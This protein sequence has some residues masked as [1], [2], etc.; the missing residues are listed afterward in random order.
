MSVPLCGTP[1]PRL[2]LLHLFGPTFPLPLP[3]PPARGD[4][5][6]VLFW[7]GDEMIIMAGEESWSFISKHSSKHLRVCGESS[8]YSTS[9]SPLIFSFV[10]FVPFVLFLLIAL[11]VFNPFI[12]SFLRSRYLC[13]VAWRSFFDTPR[14]LLPLSFLLFYSLYSGPPSFLRPTPIQ[15]PPLPP[16]AVDRGQ[17][18]RS[19]QGVLKAAGCDREGMLNS[20]EKTAGN[21]SRI[22]APR[23]MS[24]YGR[25]TWV[26]HLLSVSAL[27]D[28][29]SLGAYSSLVLGCL[30]FH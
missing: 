5:F 27:T 15:A 25:S 16:R 17:T 3:T 13:A 2:L 26:P 20:G 4:L 6:M 19:S 10:W 18:T 7:C 23:W 8:L 24:R 1:P 29:P 21:P 30:F 11:R 12:G 14:F 22:A 9:R 28:F